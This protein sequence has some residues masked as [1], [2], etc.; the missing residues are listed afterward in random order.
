M[1]ELR[2]YTTRDGVAVAREWLRGLRDK[3]S[4]ARIQMR[5]DSLARG[6]FGDC[7][8]L[9]DGVWEL[10]IDS[11]PGYRVYYAVLDNVAILLLCGGDKRRQ[12][13][14]IDRAVSYLNDYVERTR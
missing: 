3:T 2:D 5:L 14:D 13:G 11:G 12:D 10:R 7:K 8:P 1:R 4:L 6:N 9:R